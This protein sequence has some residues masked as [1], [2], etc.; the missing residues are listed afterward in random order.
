MREQ[1]RVLLSSKV[2]WVDKLSDLGTINGCIFSNELLDNFA[3]HKVIMKDTLMEVYVDY[4]HGFYEVLRPASNELV[5]YFKELGV[6]LPEGFCTEVNLEAIQWLKEISENLAKGY[7]LTIDYGHSSDDLYADK[8]KEGTLL[9]YYRHEI[10]ERP[11]LQPG[12]QD[13]TSHVNFSA[14]QHW[15]HKYGLSVC[16]LTSQAGFLGGLG[17]EEYAMDDLL[18]RKTSY[19]DL[20]RYSILKYTMMVDMGHKFKVLIQG[21]GVGDQKLSGV[22]SRSF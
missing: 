7:L 2:M 10:N 19:L 17:W 20:R 21:K 18:K 12:L 15:G 22:A 6:T 11:F 14:L 16:G 3:V 1:E 13:I 9:C 4:D 5:D 8:R